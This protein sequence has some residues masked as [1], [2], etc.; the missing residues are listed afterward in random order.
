MPAQI[1][2]ALIGPQYHGHGVPA[3]QRT[4]TALHEQVARHPGFLGHRNGIAEGR[5]DGI[6]QLSAVA[7]GSF[8]E[9]F[10]NV[11]GAINALLFD[12]RLQRI[13]PFTGLYGIIVLVHQTSPWH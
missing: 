2:R 7:A 1:T 10:E 13:Q 6:R 4:N 3:D 5:R 8:G 12:Q 9:P 11:L